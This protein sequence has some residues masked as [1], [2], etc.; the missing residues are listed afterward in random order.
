[1]QPIF[2]LVT[3]GELKGRVVLIVEKDNTGIIPVEITDEGTKIPSK[4]LREL[5]VEE[6]N[7]LTTVETIF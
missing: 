1:M 2:K 5:T 6:K 4:N 3:M 7:K